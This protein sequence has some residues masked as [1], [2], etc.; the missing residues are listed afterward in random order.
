MS[1][2]FKPPMK[3]RTPGKAENQGLFNVNSKGVN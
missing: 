3:P 2:M 1:H